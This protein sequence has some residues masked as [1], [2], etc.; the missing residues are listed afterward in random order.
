[1]NKFLS[2][3]FSLALIFG[4]SSAAYADSSAWHDSQTVTITKNYQ[5]TNDNTT[6]PAETFSFTIEKQSVTDA[7][8]GV[9]VDNM[10]VPTIGT[11]D[12][13]SG[14][15]G[16]ANAK[17]QVSLTL[18]TYPSVGIYTY[19]IHEV[20][21]SSAGVSYHNSPIL[22]RI[23][24]V[25]EST[26]LVRIAAVHTEGYG[27]KKS[28]TFPN[29]YS[30]GELSIFKTVT[31]NLGDQTKDFEVTVTFHAPEGKTVNEAI[32]YT[33]GTVPGTILPGWSGTKS[34]VIHLKHDEFVTFKNIPYGVTYRVAE[35]DYTSEGYDTAQYNFSNPS[36]IIDSAYDSVFITNNKDTNVDTG[37][38]LDSIPYL[39]ILVL[40]VGAAALYCKHKHYTNND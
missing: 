21:G 1:M 4:I 18:P 9:T 36:K 17:K 28:D 25:Q 26:G 38:H 3:L 13:T 33:E 34:V 40:I 39:I 5:T 15:A 11:I 31:G 14:E 22:L 2:V 10:P 7:A 6:S 19:L 37:I 12:Y 30:A 23:T 32:T 8:E 20:T 24:V 16:S 35:A 27:G 29:V